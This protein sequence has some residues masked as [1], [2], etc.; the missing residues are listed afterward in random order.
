MRVPLLS[1]VP[2]PI[3]SCENLTISLPKCKGY[4]LINQLLLKMLASTMRQEKIN[5]KRSKMIPKLPHPRGSAEKWDTNNFCTVVFMTL[6]VKSPLKVGKMINMYGCIYSIQCIKHRNR[7]ENTSRLKKW[8][9][10]I[11][12]CPLFLTW[13]KK[14][15]KVRPSLINYKLSATLMEKCNTFPPKLVKAII[16]KIKKNKVSALCEMSPSNP[17][18]R[19]SGKPLEEEAERV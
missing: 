2:A 9:L 1:M 13:K 19:S 8:H 18:P 6:L 5:W 3:G 15:K 10:M 12:N 17:C 16:Q 4:T 11:E 7:P 14:H